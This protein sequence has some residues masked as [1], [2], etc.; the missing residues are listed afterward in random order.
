MNCTF[1]FDPIALAEYMEAI[2][3]YGERSDVAYDNFI[4][5]VDKKITDICTAPTSFRNSY[6][7]YRK[8]SLKTF[9]YSIVYLLDEKLKLVTITSIYHHKRSPKR[10]YKK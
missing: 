9:P 4:S 7:K 10:K 1:T 2:A 3:W 6:R 8:T 5:E